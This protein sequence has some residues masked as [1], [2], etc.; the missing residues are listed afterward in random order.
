MSMDPVINFQKVISPW[1]P[2]N[3]QSVPYYLSTI[4]SISEPTQAS[5]ESNTVQKG[6]WKCSI[7]GSSS[8]PVS[9]SSCGFIIHQVPFSSAITI[10][11]DS[12]R[13]ILKGSRWEWICGIHGL[14]FDLPSKSHF[15]SIF[16][17]IIPSNA[18]FSRTTH[19]C[20]TTLGRNL[21]ENQKFWKAFDL[22]SPVPRSFLKSLFPH[23]LVRCIL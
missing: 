10:H 13:E 7:F 20:K 8:C 15:I 14:K 16:L 21:C 2:I 6:T 1:F 17:F 9:L 23:N 5:S 3:V 11:V 22:L 18:K 4:Q 12:I 19:R